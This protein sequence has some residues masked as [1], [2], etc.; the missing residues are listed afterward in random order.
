MNAYYIMIC[1]MSVDW[2]FV[3]MQFAENAYTDA[4]LMPFDQWICKRIVKFAEA[5]SREGRV[6]SRWCEQ[7]CDIIDNDDDEL[8][9]IDF[10][11]YI[12]LLCSPGARLR[13]E[14]ATANQQPLSSSLREQ[15]CM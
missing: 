15:V 5:W 11:E 8:L 2:C 10:I 7:F 14:S 13:K 12:F 4:K 1:I 9:Y 3:D 6:A